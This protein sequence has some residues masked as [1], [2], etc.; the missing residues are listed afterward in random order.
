MFSNAYILKFTVIMCVICAVVLAF[1]TTALAPIHAKNEAVFNKRAILGALGS[2]L[3][4]PLA[5]M[6]DEEVLTLFEKNIQQFAVKADGNATEGKDAAIKIDLSQEKKK[7]E[8]ERQ[9]PLF[10]YTGDKGTFYLVAVR[11]SGLWDEIWGT[12]AL[13]GDM[14]TVAG[15]SFDHK[16]ETPGLGAEIKDNPKFSG[17]FVGRKLFDDKG[18]FVS[19]KVRKGGAVDKTHEVD[20]ISGATI[21]S[22]GVSEMLH[23]G[24]GYY[25]PYLAK[26]KKQ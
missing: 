18:N 10:V 13:E 4:K 7:P 16:A 9:F 23:R 2:N 3:P 14:N 15:T 21:T 8:A 20:A 12:L 25:L 24:I 22:K 26:L 1:E 17:Q 6:S 19:V 5:E 11:G